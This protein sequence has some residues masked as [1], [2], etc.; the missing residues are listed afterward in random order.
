MAKGQSVLLILS[1]EHG[2]NHVPAAYRRLFHGAR[3]VLNSHRGFDLGALK[4]AKMMSRRLEAPLVASTTSR[5]L[6]DLNRSLDH[7]RLFSSY[8][9]VLDEPAR[10][11]V[12]RLY[13]HPYRARVEEL[14]AEQIRLGR[15]VLHV[16]VH[17][18]TPVLDGKERH[19]D[20]GLLY[21]PTRQREEAF[22][23]CWRTA[24]WERQPELRVRRNY[25]YR[26]VSDSLT[27]SLRERYPAHRYAGVELEVNQ[28]WPL[29]GQPPLAAIAPYPGD[30]AAGNCQRSGGWVVGGG[31][32]VVGRRAPLSR[33][34]E[35]G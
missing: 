24:L 9:E 34:R 13:Y 25:P 12:L 11:R 30:D 3:D 6:V 8:S 32:W 10:A 21:D 35:R 33:L 18:F 4:V 5:L 16:S 19:A 23:D 1:C 31:S 14:V 27:V 20:V 17:S 7:R 29:A 2:G 15:A 22:C 28:S 26:G